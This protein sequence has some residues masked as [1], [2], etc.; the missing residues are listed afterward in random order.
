MSFGLVQL[1][2]QNGCALGVSLAFGIWVPAH[3]I[4][5]PTL[6][7]EPL[8][9]VIEIDMVSDISS[10]PDAS[11]IVE[12]KKTPSDDL[13]LLGRDPFSSLIGNKRRSSR[14][15][16]RNAPG[17]DRYVVASGDKAFLFENL[18]SQARLRFLCGIDDERIDCLIDDD[19]PAEEIHVLTPVSAGRG[20]T[21]YKDSRGET[22]LRIASYGGA[23]I[24]WPGEGRG[25]AASKSY[26]D[27]PSLSLQFADHEVVTRRLNNATALLSAKTGAPV[28]FQIR[29]NR[30]DEVAGAA[31]L[32]DA[33]SRAASGLAFVASD[34]TGSRVIGAR[35][36]SVIFEFAE[37]S[38]L[39]LTN[40]DFIVGYNP[41]RGLSGRPSSAR[42]VEFLENQL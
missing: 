17:V 37:Q 31:V 11:L 26:S 21:I 10:L 8:A 7:S 32:A 39:K 5:T 14:Q 38:S 4:Q 30:E 29:T 24:Y 20:D 28:V 16:K 15:K 25:L 19:V 3:A 42:I 40:Q 13:A 36:K 6:I 9:A 35:I 12:T 27:D 1:M 33:I 23:T 22:L 34:T 41:N 18:G 2:L